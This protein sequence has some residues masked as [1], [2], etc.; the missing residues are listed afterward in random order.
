LGL[1][2]LS[3]TGIFYVY[4]VARKEFAYFLKVD[5]SLLD[6]MFSLLQRFLG[7]VVTDFTGCLHLRH[8]NELGG[9]AY[10]LCVIWAEI[11]PFVTLQ[12]LNETSVNLT[13]HDEI[14]LS[15]CLSAGLWLLVNTLFLCSI[16]LEYIDT[17][18]SAKT[19]QK[20]AVEL[21]LECKEDFQRFEVVTMRRPTFFDEIHDEVKL[22]VAENIDGWVRDCPP[23]F[24]ISDIHDDLL[25]THTLDYVGY[26]SKRRSNSFWKIF[27]G[28]SQSSTKVTPWQGEV[29]PQCRSQQSS[30]K[31]WCDLAEECYTTSRG[32]SYEINLLK[33]TKIFHEKEYVLPLLKLCPRFT[34][35]VSAILEDKLRFRTLRNGGT[36]VLTDWG[37]AECTR[38]GQSLS[39]FLRRKDSAVKAVKAWQRLY[40]ELNPLF[41]E[42]DGFEEFILLIAN[43]LLR[44]SVYGRVSRVAIG[45][46]LSTLDLVTDMVMLFVYSRNPELEWQTIALL[47]MIVANVFFQVAFSL[48]Q[49]S[50]SSWIVRV[51]EVLYTLFFLRPAVDAHR[52]GACEDKAATYET[53]KEVI[54]SRCAD[55]ATKSIF[56]C[57]LQLSVLI[58]QQNGAQMLMPLLSVVLT[59]LSSGFT[60]AMI[61]YDSDISS[62]NRRNQREFYGFI[63]D[64]KS[65]RS[66]CFTLLALTSALHNLSRGIGC[67][68]LILASGPKLIGG[69][70]C[71]ELLF[72]MLFKV[73]V[74]DFHS[75]IR[76]ESVYSVWLSTI[77]RI[78]DY[79]VVAFT[80][81]VLLRHPYH[82]GGLAFSS[83]LVWSQ[84]F[85]FV[86][87]LFC[88]GL[89]EEVTQIT[90][91]AVLVCNLI[92]WVS[93]NISL[94]FSINLNYIRTFF[95]T[96]TG[97]Q[98]A[99]QLF[100]RSE[101]HGSKFVAVFSNRIDH[102][103]SIHEEIKEWLCLNI[104]VWTEDKPKWFSIDLVPNDFL[105]ENVFVEEGGS[106]RRK[107]SSITFR[108][109][110]K[111][112]V[113]CL[114]NAEDKSSDLTGTSNLSSTAILRVE[115]A[116]WK[117][118]AEDIFETRSNNRE[119]NIIHINRIFGDNKTLVTPLIERCP[120][121]NEILSII[122]EG[123]FAFRVQQVDR[124]ID[125]KSWGDEECKRVGGSLALFLRKRK[126]GDTAIDAWRRNYSQLKL[127][128]DEVEGFKDF[129]LAIAG[130]MM[131]DSIYGVVYRVTVGA[132]LST[133]DA[134]TDIFVMLNYYYVGLGTQASVMMSM[135]SINVVLQV[136]IS[137]G[138]YKMK[139]WRVKLRE[140]LICL[141][142]LRPAVDAYRVST[143]ERDGTLLEP[144]TAMMF[145]K[146]SE[147]AT[148]AIPGVVLQMYVFLLNP[149]K[150]GLSALISIFVSNLT[151]GFTSAMISFDFDISVHH[152]RVQPEFYGYVPDDHEARTRCFISM[153]LA[154]ALH[155]FSRSLGI[156]LL[157]AVSGKFATYSMLVEMLL[158]L[159]YKMLRRDFLYWPKVERAAIPL[160]LGN[161]IIAKVIVDFSGCFQFRHPKEV[162]GFAF[163]FS[164]LWAQAMP[165]FALLL[166]NTDPKTESN[167]LVIIML[168]SSLILWVGANITFFSSIDSTYW[169]TFFNTVTGPQYVC[170]VFLGSTDEHKKFDAAFSNR[171]SY[172]KNI[173]GTVKE[174]VANNIDSWTAE[175]PDWFTV[176][177]IPDDFL[178]STVLEQVGGLT[179][180]RSSVRMKDII[181][182]EDNSDVR[183]T[184]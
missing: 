7:K 125:M 184:E 118:M 150:A 110:V 106:S 13:H 86:A 4:K 129:M 152:R 141:F 9:L 42:I 175:R 17:F 151:T 116:K 27:K 156:A 102:T 97:P 153:T 177:K 173:H 166:Y 44:D 95:I 34:V 140:V 149:D 84:V 113:A 19:A 2:V 111:E 178:P 88:G 100:E 71:S 50:G 83:F 165:F 30:S 130:G 45:A 74:G 12:L 171:M 94:L 87:L 76:A 163:C 124:A 98:Y 179:R 75:S 148:E 176:E 139:S 55:L 68:L 169:K 79:N 167:A 72:Y 146:A 122:L 101:N 162:G 90:I 132:I 108:D 119:S 1:F 23:W 81:C 15:L 105:P 53:L 170:S 38:A 20:Y 143:D 29:H 69:F 58:S 37:E 159:V 78:I 80:G 24:D 158:Y 114:A 168:V 126:T 43:N 103:K 120:R 26:R 161:R 112:F 46:L 63:P 35:M 93:L 25:P 51:K 65:K 128:F 57:I 18:Y 182:F 41:N 56:S 21:F 109:S 61:A 137:L 157:A 127:L 104:D 36:K 181:G 133:V 123:K 33:I 144:L 31:K 174:W 91:I 138:Q 59:T 32:V 62:S 77:V 154:S 5:G 180:R 145:N 85:P 40:P 134:A 54:V 60:T 10:S 16:N 47:S 6:F 39:V 131:R 121:F 64:E 107:R 11:F 67:A 115:T 92:L 96:L 117:N 164:M 8:P 48:V 160:A 89:L 155:N 99:C 183:T 14:L 49:Y 28:L 73:A 172:T 136:F 70:I 66:R 82:M 3:E 147:L 135:L 52:I 142:F 22:W